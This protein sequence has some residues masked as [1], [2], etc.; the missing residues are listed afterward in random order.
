MSW[1][2][3]LASPIIS[4]GANILGGIFGMESQEKSDTSNLQAVRETNQFNKQ[5]AAINRSWTERQSSIDRKM[6]QEFAQHGV[7]W[8]AADARA[9]GLDPIVAMGSS[10]FY[11]PV[12]KALSPAQAVP[13]SPSRGKDYSW[14]GRAGQNIGSAIDRF[15]TKEQIANKVAMDRLAI[16]NANLRND[17]QMMLNMEKNRDL[18]NYRT[19]V[20]VPAPSGH[21]QV[22]DGQGDAVNILPDQVTRHQQGHKAGVHAMKQ[23]RVGPPDR[24][25]RMPVY[26]AIEQEAGDAMDADLP[27]KARYNVREFKKVFNSWT[28][29]VPPKPKIKKNGYHL[30]WNKGMAQWMFVPNKPGNSRSVKIRRRIDVPRDKKNLRNPTFKRYKIYN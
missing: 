20:G 11:S 6:Q 30:E 23:Y 25:G 27:T 22:M 16:E 13:G 12:A 4:A 5:E 17:Y 26:S 2:S 29:K 7:S 28:G 21:S 8:K 3:D 1:L 15:L 19:Q 18:M 10:T 14:M 24:Q 9:A